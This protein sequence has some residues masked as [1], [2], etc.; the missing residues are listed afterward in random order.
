VSS[1]SALK[2]GYSA[3]VEQD[4]LKAFLEKWA[5][6][7]IEVATNGDDS[8]LA[9]LKPEP[10]HYALRGKGLLGEPLLGPC[11]VGCGAGEVLSPGRDSLWLL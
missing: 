7:V 3:K 10:L 1:L 4:F 2:I 6:A 11:E 8:Q 9:E 5:G